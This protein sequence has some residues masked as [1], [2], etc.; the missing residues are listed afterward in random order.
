MN[1]DKIISGTVT[2]LCIACGALSGLASAAE[3]NQG[4]HV[5]KRGMQKPKTKKYSKAV[6]K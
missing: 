2:A 5:L 4:I 6:K 3:V 1:T